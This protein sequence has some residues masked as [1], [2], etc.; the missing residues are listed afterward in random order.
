MTIMNQITIPQPLKK[1]IICFIIELCLDLLILLGIGV[2]M[3]IGLVSSFSRLFGP[4]DDDIIALVMLFV[5]GSGFLLWGIFKLI[6]LLQ[7]RKQKQWAWIAALVISAL[8]LLSFPY[9]VLGI[10]KL[11]GL[12][13]ND[14]TTWF[15]GETKSA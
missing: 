2:V 4:N 9:L 6:V 15:K 5:L 10:I 7:L 8:N 14:V 3:I 11:V 1:T 13:N 12:L